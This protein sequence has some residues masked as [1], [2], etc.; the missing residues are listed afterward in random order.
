MSFKVLDSQLFVTKI[1]A[2]FVWSTIS[3]SSTKVHNFQWCLCWELKGWQ[4]L[5]PIRRTYLIEMSKAGETSSCFQVLLPG[6]WE[7]RYQGLAFL[8]SSLSPPGW[9]RLWTLPCL[10]HSCR[11]PLLW[12]EKVVT[13]PNT[14]SFAVWAVVAWYTNCACSIY[15]SCF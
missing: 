4:T 7:T 5:G 8:S 15:G 11:S 2:C 12:F 14:F 13:T 9:Q 3:K 6:H 1:G 10:A